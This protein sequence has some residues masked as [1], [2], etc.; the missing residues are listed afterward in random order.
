MALNKREKKM[1]IATCGVVLVAGVTL[2][3]GGDDAPPQ[4][5][6]AA[7]PIAETNVPAPAAPDPITRETNSSEPESAGAPSGEA[8]V[9]VATLEL[10]LQLDRMRAAPGPVEF[11]DPFRTVVTAV[12][13]DAELEAL[14]QDL[15]HVSGVFFSS[16]TDRGAVLDGKLVF[17]N[18]ACG[19]FRLHAVDPNGVVLEADGRTYRIE[20]D[21]LTGGGFQKGEPNE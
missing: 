2:F 19:S 8:P 21:P 13:Q 10:Q 14:S 16:A 5:E 6:A 12:E 17:L 4:A 7:A 15:P 18:Q 1:L 9:L 20:F 3:L 11:E